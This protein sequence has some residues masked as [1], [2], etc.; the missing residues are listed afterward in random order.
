MEKYAKFLQE[1]RCELIKKSP[2]V[3]IEKYC[4]DEEIRWYWEINEKGLN[5][6]LYCPYCGEELKN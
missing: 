4:V 2:F 5:N 6:I 3:R 1:H